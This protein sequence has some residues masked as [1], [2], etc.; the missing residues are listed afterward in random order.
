MAEINKEPQQ[1][2]NAEQKRKI[3]E[4][5]IRRQRLREVGQP[6]PAPATDRGW[7]RK[8]L[9]GDRGRPR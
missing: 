1:S 5:S 9:Y 3:L 8:E 6:K 2:L 7:T 4:E